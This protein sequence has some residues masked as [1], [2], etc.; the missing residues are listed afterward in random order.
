MQQFLRDI[1]VRRMVLCVL[2]LVSALVIVLA[3]LGTRG[4][5]YAEKALKDSGVLLKHV[6]SLNHV[7]DQLVL[8]RLHL[9]Q[10][11][12]Y[13]AARDQEKQS[14]ESRSVDEALVAA[15]QNF[16]AF[17]QSAQSYVPQS[18]VQSLQ[19]GFQALDQ[20]I[21][22]QQNFLAAGDLARA[23]E[24]EAKV[25]APAS[26]AFAD[27]LARY[28][29][30]GGT[31]EDQLLQEAHENRME[32][33]IGAAVVAG[34]CLLLVLLGDRYVVAC[35]KRPLDDIKGHFRRI[36][37]GDLTQPIAPFGKNCVGQ[38]IPFLDDM[39]NSLSRTVG[40]V[41]EGVV[42]INGGAAGIAAGNSDLSS[43]TEEQAS[44]L[45]E[46]AAS[47]E[48]LASTVHNNA[49]NAGHARDM[50]AQASENAQ[51]G[52]AAVQQ[53]VA[54]MRKISD[55]S[56]RI[57][58][59]TAVIDSIAF[60]TNI[61]ALNAAVEAARAG[62]QGKGFAVVASE[63]RTLA[64][65][66]AAAS[67]EIRDLIA[68]SSATVA[69]GSHQVEAA[70][71]TMED[72]LESVQRLATLVGEIATASHEQAAGIEQVNTALTQMD[73]VTQ[74][75]AALVE[76][77]AAAASALE[78]QAQRLQNAV[79]LFRLAGDGGALPTAPKLQEIE[80]SIPGA[81]GGR[82]ALPA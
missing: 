12:D 14:A 45:E 10:L 17:T 31:R 26:R 56:R 4:L 59:I 55:S 76:Q 36:A 5:V 62:E 67:K 40:A 61:L 21:A 77:A 39:Q 23:A 33:F 42:Q 79:A 24:Q 28:E 57:G 41:R 46:T 7:N 19:S 27:T 75:N 51:R 78:T 63:V 71:V 20:G 34:I 73:Q 80:H 64:Q 29:S 52:G 6:S 30:Y 53:A 8:A 15:R 35:V 38:I 37:S 18:L 2:L 49:Q 9:V 32:S 11:K 13:A 74:Q 25:V 60:Q 50:A 48:E 16:E 43:R 65:R 22:G 58:D 47:M 3:F 82:L 66:S 44:S 54:T 70:G 68:A 81:G 69:E 1:T 72:I